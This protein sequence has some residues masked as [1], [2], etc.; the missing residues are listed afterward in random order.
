MDGIIALLL[1]KKFTKDTVIGMGAIKGA[2]CQVQSIN[3]VGKTTTVT[4][5]WEDNT[6]GIH[7]QSFEIEDGA[8][9][10]SVSNATI[11]ASGNLIL[12]LSDGNTIDCG[13]VLPQYD[14]M[15]TP[16]SS[17][18]GQILQ[19]IGTTT[20]DY[21]NG[22]FYECIND[23]GVYKWVEK[24]VQDSYTKS[25]IGNLNDL[26]DNTKNVVE[27]IST[28]KLSIDQ[29]SASKLS[30]TDIDN[31][32]ST[33][34]ENP[35]QNKVIT[36]AL[37]DKENKF[38][39]TLIP[40]ASASDIGKIIQYIG[41]NTSSLTSG[42]YYQCV[43]VSTGVYDWVQK[44][45]QP[46]NG[47]TGG[48]GVV[49]GYYNSTD[50]LFYEDIAHTNPISGD[51]NT[52]YVS[53]DTNLVY[54]F[55]GIIFIRV[56]EVV[57]EDD[58]I[59]GYYY[60]TDG[61]FY[62]D[63][64]Y[65]TE[66]T[67]ETG[68]IYISIDTNIQYRWDNISIPN[69]F[70]P[71]SATIDV[72]DVFSTT[73]TNPV[74][75]KVITT[76]INDIDTLMGSKVDK[77][78]GKGLST[79]DYTDEDK[80][81]VVDLAPI[82]LIGSGL[83]LDTTVGSPTYGKLQATGMSIP[84][85][86]ELSETSINPVQ[87]K[88]IALKID[89]LQGS[90]LDKI[91]KRLSAQEDNFAVWNNDGEIEDSGISKD[92]IPTTA[93]ASNKVLVKSDVDNA[94]STS[95]ENP[96]QNKEITVPLQA[97]QGSMSNVKL[98]ITDLQG[99][100]LDIK[101]DITDLQ[102]D[103]QDK[104]TEGNGIDIDSSNNISLDIS[105]L[106]ASR[107]G[108]IP[109]AEKGTANG[110]A[111]LDST[112]KVPSSQLPSN[113]LNDLSDVVIT[114]PV[115]KQILAYNSTSNKWENQ[116]GQETIGG[117]VYKGSILFANLP[118]TGMVNGDSYDIKDAFVT[119][120]RFEEG[121][122]IACG[123]GTDVAWV[124]SDNKWNILTPSG[125]FLFNGRTGAVLPAKSDYDANQIDYDNTTSGLTATDVQDTIDELSSE[126]A[127]KVTSATNGHLAGLN[128]NGNLTDSGVVASNV[129]Q[130]VA[131]ATGLLKDDGTVDTTSY[132]TA[133]NLS[134]HI[135]NT[136]NP[137]KVTKSQVGLGSVVNTGD[138]ATPV[139]GG[140][141]KFTTGG[142]YVE[143]NKKY[144]INDTAETSLVDG[145]YIPF[146]DTSA[147][148]KR[149]TLWSNIK[150][151]LKTYFDTIYSTVK[152]RQTPASG[153]TTLSLV[154]TGDMYSWNNKATVNG[155]TMSPASGS[156]ES[157]IVSTINGATNTNTNV[158]SLYSIQKWTNEKRVRRVITGTT[159]IGSASIGSTGIGK[160]DDSATPTETDW[161]Y[162][163]AFKI[164]DSRNDID[165]SLKFDP[166][167]GEP[168]TLGGYILDTTT[169]RLCIKFGN[170]IATP[171]NAKIAVD[172]TY[173]RNEFS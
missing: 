106:T 68:K 70:V 95:S 120:N 129:I 49:D 89:Q 18:E 12:T 146:Y 61:K 82:Y 74:Q 103:K 17:N 166:S 115:N 36:D 97:L 157:T 140:T 14:T 163:A 154:N 100:V 155:H 63:S 162:D 62:E 173:T 5:K 37:D 59:N 41:S 50:Q 2:A 56:D 32:L 119:D 38:R 16:S 64:T 158:G 39:V 21:T 77:E 126:K 34:S 46:S 54:R 149:K 128:A 57:G 76:K 132:A 90:V 67:G 152:S 160:W 15:P 9:G 3:K 159:P 123:A 113:E 79:N 111:E 98:D 87:N 171:A 10:V 99:S 40:I 72:D 75:N 124:E 22:Y 19:Y 1:S 167:S 112:G 107:V 147:T 42:Y 53:V 137:H 161:W 134:S 55:N 104:L 83:T 143:L 156:A 117:I 127:D 116:T 151:V 121:S 31:V 131:T 28:I 130:K 91:R 65:T 102:N 20:S 170:S 172:I 169:G 8:D 144:D 24:L 81:K 135:S 29:L 101:S 78:T 30:K 26:P 52:L 92:I 153:G 85:D 66:I 122:G 94:L 69:K 44:N 25:E 51:S 168:V 84:I 136:S 6:G 35:V 13:K 118:T 108:Y 33:T 71:I 80:Q 11:N 93:S 145:D 48:D 43:E 133:S 73:S 141:T 27:N 165:L 142:A 58:V 7:T 114:S 138:S 110:V 47:G 139:N 86:D 105:Y 96:V 109:N 4:L 23:S 150:S 148:A 60:T 164:P 88:V 45:V 125:V